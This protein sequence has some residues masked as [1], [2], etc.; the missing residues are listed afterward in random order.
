METN[1]KKTFRTMGRAAAR[2]VTLVEVLIVV[3]IMAVISGGAVVLA[4]PLYK[5]ARIKTAVVSA[6]EIKKAAQLYQ[7]MDAT[8][9]GCPTIQDLV[10]AKRLDLTTANDPWGKAFR[11]VCGEGD[12]RVLSSGNDRKDNSPDDIRDDFTPVDVKKAKE[13]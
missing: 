7:E 11:I 1:V 10:T 5:E 12:I 9:E 3:S 13:L 2:G 4:F 6:K 8:T